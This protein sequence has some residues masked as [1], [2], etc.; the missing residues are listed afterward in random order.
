MQRWYVTQ[1]RLYSLPTSRRKNLSASLSAIE[2]FG[3]QSL[4]ESL[5]FLG[6]NVSSFAAFASIH[7]QQTSTSPSVHDICCQTAMLRVVRRLGTFTTFRNPPRGTH[8]I[9]VLIFSDAERPST[10]AQIGFV[11]RLLNGS[12][13]HGSVLHTVSWAS[14]ISKR[15]AKSSGS[16]EVLAARDV[17]D[18]GK[19]SAKVYSSLLSMKVYLYFCIAS[20]HLYD[21]LCTCQTPG[22]K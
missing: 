11:G 4:N 9:F 14:H 20:K 21:S 17:I 22:D 3:F 1:N 13:T 6:M 5:S 15:P 2:P 18:I 19:I 10:H 8:A 12:S 16:A 7:L